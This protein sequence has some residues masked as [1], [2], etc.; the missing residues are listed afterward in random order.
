MQQLLDEDNSNLSSGEVNYFK[1]NT[2]Y[3][4]EKSENSNSCGESYSFSSSS[5]SSDSEEV[6]SSKSG[7]SSSCESNKIG[8][9]TQMSYLDDSMTV[10]TEKLFN[11]KKSA[12][13]N[14]S[15]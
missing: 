12:P 10:A 13:A 8:T 5:T 1:D 4:H 11:I 15:E 7:D 2:L 14:F 3:N 9:N 6:L